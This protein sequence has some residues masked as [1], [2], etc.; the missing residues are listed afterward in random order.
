MATT[1][2]VLVT[3]ATGLQGGAVVDALLAAKIPVRALVRDVSSTKAQRLA[4]RGVALHEGSFDDLNSIVE[5]AHG[6]NGLFSV[7]LATEDE[8]SHARNL[9]TAAQRAGVSTLVHTSVARAGDHQEFPDW[10]GEWAWYWLG[11]AAANDEVRNSGVPHWV[12]LKPAL[13][14]DNFADPTASSM[15]PTLADGVLASTLR[16]ET[17][18]DLI[19]AADVGAFAAAAFAEPNRFDHREIPLAAQSLTMEQVAATLT[20]VSG[21]GLAVRSLSAEEGVAVGIYEGTVWSRQWANDVGYQVD[22]AACRAYG[23]PMTDFAT[24]A[25]AHRAACRS[26]TDGRPRI[27]PRST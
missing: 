13:M 25:A 10:L 22:I 26:S 4:A 3:G 18:M 9:A 17:R 7:Q 5:A 19:A 14:M 2:D 8:A 15:F 20:R 27:N 21:T 6:A 1:K 11:K 16:P 23:V 24:W 12:I